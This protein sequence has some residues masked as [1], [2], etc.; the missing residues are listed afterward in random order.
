M[1]RRG[2]RSGPSSETRE[3]LGRAERL[4]LDEGYSLRAA[5]ESV[6]LAPST[7]SKAF[8]RSAA[9]TAAPRPDTSRPGDRDD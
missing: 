8:S 2:I 1:P 7:L 6:G 5:A 4:M 9:P 3:K